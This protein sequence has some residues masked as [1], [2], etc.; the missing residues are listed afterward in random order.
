MKYFSATAA[1]LVLLL[2]SQGDLR[3][4][5]SINPYPLGQGSKARKT[6]S[7]PVNIRPDTTPARNPFVGAAPSSMQWQAFKGASA[8]EVLD[9]WS[10]DAGVEIIWNSNED[11]SIPAT[12]KLAGSYESAVEALLNQY[13]NEYGR[14]VGNLYVDPSSGKKTLVISTFEGE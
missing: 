7:E 13:G 5:I 9:S 4:E 11:Y 2:A 8:H 14:P 12:V 10:Q 3:A 6:S 1:A